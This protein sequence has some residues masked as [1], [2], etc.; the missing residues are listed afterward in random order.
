MKNHLWFRSH[1]SVQHA[2]LE[3][4]E[5]HDEISK[6]EIS[7]LRSSWWLQGDG[8]EGHTDPESNRLVQKVQKSKSLN[9]KI[10]IIILEDFLEH[11]KLI[12]FIA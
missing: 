1:L 8:G 7:F 4:L 3:N 11:K 12:F 10:A 5:N 2:K 9:R 6:T